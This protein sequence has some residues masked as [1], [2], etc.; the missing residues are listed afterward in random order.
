MVRVDIA[1]DSKQ[2]NVPIDGAPPIPEER[3][4]G[5]GKSAAKNRLHI[6]EKSAK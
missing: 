2:R 6:D 1:D 4:V 3:L 5:T